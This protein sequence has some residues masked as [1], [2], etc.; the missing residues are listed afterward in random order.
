MFPKKH[1]D[2]SKSHHSG[3][4]SPFKNKRWLKGS[5]YTMECA[6]CSGQQ[7]LAFKS[8]QNMTCRILYMNLKYIYIYVYIPFVSS[9]QKYHMYIS[10]YIHINHCIV[11]TQNDQTH[12]MTSTTSGLLSSARETTMR[13]KPCTPGSGLRVMTTFHDFY[14]NMFD[15]HAAT[16]FINVCKG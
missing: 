1:L 7:K 8:S 3:C 6:R 11:D 15:E 4:T 9:S 16:C 13:R 5:L 12:L 2:H 10:I 14:S